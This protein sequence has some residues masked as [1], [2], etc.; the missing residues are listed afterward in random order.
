[1]RQPF[2]VALTEKSFAD[3]VRCLK[4]FD[5]V[6]TTE[7]SVVTTVLSVKA[8]D[9]SAWRT[10]FRRLEYKPNFAVA[11]QISFFSVHFENMYKFVLNTFVLN[12]KNIKVK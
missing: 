7:K 9:L 11:Q 8:T 6:E 3:F 10:V 2:S 12:P 1:V 5:V 4:K